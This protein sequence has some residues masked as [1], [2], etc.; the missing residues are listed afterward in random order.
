M[1]HISD[2]V[3][4]EITSLENLVDRMGTDSNGNK[5]AAIGET[6]SF[7]YRY[8]MYKNVLERDLPEFTF[9]EILKFNEFHHKFR[10]VVY[11]G[12]SYHEFLTCLEYEQ[13]IKNLN[14]S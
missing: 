3:F 10:D 4:N 11:Q 7:I 13:R 5:Y 12:N 2:K 8:Q 6:K 14:K 9:D 1:K